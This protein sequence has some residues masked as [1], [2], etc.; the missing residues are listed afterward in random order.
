MTDRN[1]IIPAE[2]AVI[3]NLMEVCAEIDAALLWQQYQESQ[4]AMP[5]ALDR[6]CRDT[7]TS[8][9]RRIAVRQCIRRTLKSA[10]CVLFVL[11]L[12]GLLTL[13]LSSKARAAM[14]QWF[15]QIE[16]TAFAYHPVVD[17][18]R[19]IQKLCYTIGDI[20]EGFT[21]QQEMR[22]DYSGTIIYSNSQENKFLFLY[23][24]P[25]G[26][27]NLYLMQDDDIK[28]AGLV[29]G[30]PADLYLSPIAEN[31]S[32]IV[33]IDS[34]TGYLLMVTGVFTEQELIAIA[35]SVRCDPI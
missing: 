31:K 27:G 8:H 4:I 7:M 1:K 12:T 9:F 18:S 15:Q 28:K 24:A 30:D 17:H 10:A 11:A 3:V 33:W 35:E 21:V 26:S 16:G 32:N 6:K 19:E 2:D 23:S 29:N 22:T 13:C 5:D 25:D 20:P 14:A 34:D